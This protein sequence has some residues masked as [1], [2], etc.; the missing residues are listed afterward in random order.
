MYIHEPLVTSISANGKFRDP[1]YN[2][3]HQYC[4]RLMMFKKKKVSKWAACWQIK[5]VVD[6]SKVQ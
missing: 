1:E 5:F 3:I 6:A 2:H 4:V